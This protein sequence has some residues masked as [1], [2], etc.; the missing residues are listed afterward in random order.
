MTMRKKK[1]LLKH[2]LSNVVYSD[3]RV[4][5]I[6]YSDEYFFEIGKEMTSDLGEAVCIL[7][8]NFDFNHEIWNLEIDEIDYEK[9]VPEKSL[10][11][12]TGAYS[13]WSTLENYKQ[14]WQECYLDFQ[15][16]FGFIIINTI[17]KYKKLSEIRNT[18]IKNLSLPILYDFAI[19]RNL[20]R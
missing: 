20:V 11:W 17:K 18:F 2:D 3:D 6:K 5:V 1:D 12:L 14:P 16:E 8:R 19:S 7:M 4:K 10:F 9:I 13:E 15:E